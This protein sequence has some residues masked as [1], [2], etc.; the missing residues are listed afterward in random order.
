MKNPFAL[1]FDDPE[2]IEKE[3]AEKEEK[4]AA[5]EKEMSEEEFGKLSEAQ[6]QEFFEKDVEEKTKEKEETEEEEPEEEESEEETQDEEESEEES[7]EEEEESE[8][9]EESEE[10]EE[11]V[12]VTEKRLKD[13]QK[14]FRAARSENVELK[15]RL[16]EV[17]KKVEASKPKEETKPAELTLATIKPEVLQRALKE[18]PVE[19]MRWVADQQVKQ[20]LEENRKRTEH[21]S[22]EVERVAFVKQSEEMALKKFPVLKEILDM[23]PEELEKLKTTHNTKY[24]FGQKTSKYFK[25]F[26][27]RGDNEAFYNA[28]ARAYVELSPKMIKEVQSETKRLAEQELANKKRVLGKVSVSGNHGVLGTKNA[29]KPKNLSEEEFMKLTPSQQMEHWER[30]FD[31]KT[32][33]K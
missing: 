23:K 32:K 18:N 25:E 31:S 1:F 16:D 15:K 33:K 21:D 19:T 8:E 9:G 4:P 14:A 17:E 24:L 20:S 29:S 13:T 28:A 27:A 2:D 30:D 3:V 22:K 7:E 11:D 26:A 12:P 6:Q 10:A 5:S